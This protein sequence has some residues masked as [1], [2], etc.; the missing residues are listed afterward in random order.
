MAWVRAT[1]APCS[2]PWWHWPSAPCWQASSP[3][4]APPPL[5]PCAPYEPTDRPNPSGPRRSGASVAALR[6]PRPLSGNAEPGLR[7]PGEASLAVREKRD[8]GVSRQGPVPINASVISGGRLPVA[9]HED[10]NLILKLY[11]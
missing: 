5:T 1:P 7:G 9:D 10:A 11:E 8:V 6:P 3:P 4:A 2:A